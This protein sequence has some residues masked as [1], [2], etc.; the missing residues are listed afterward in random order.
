MVKP[1]KPIHCLS[2]HSVD[3][4]VA[5]QCVPLVA[6]GQVDRCTGQNQLNSGTFGGYGRAVTGAG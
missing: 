1:D 4:C 5:F 2:I 6:L 3:T